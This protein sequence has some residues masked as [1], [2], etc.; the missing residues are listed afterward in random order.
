MSEK[1]KLKECPFCGGEASDSGEASYSG[2]HEAWW[3]D[4][5]VMLKAF[6]CNCIECGITNRGLMGHQIKT[7]A[8]KA[9]NKR[10]AQ[11]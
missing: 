1:I 6:F 11:K 7:L 8:V 5:S 9:W 2:N 3:S 10:E 4:G